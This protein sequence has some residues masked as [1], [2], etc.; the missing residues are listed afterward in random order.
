MREFDVIYNKYAPVIQKY[1]LSLGADE[2]LS[3]DITADT[4][5][6]AM[7][8]ID[9]YNENCKMT[10]WLCTI[11]KNT[12]L[13]HLKKKDNN[14]FSIDENIL[15]IASSS[16]PQDICEE[17]ETKRILYRAISNLE[18]LYKDVVY[19]RGFADLSF[20]EIGEVLGKNEN[21]ARVTFYR[22]KMLLKGMIENEI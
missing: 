13:N 11:A 16:S 4:F 8:N 9:S 17:N 15:E 7:K 2:T 22:G 21:W 18:M 3:Q 1:I 14:N 6:K 5:M 20:K 12:Y 10:T 19:L